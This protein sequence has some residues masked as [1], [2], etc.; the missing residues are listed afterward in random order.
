MAGL[1]ELMSL[2]QFEEEVRR[3]GRFGSNVAIADPLA[4]ALK[5]ISD[6]PAC[7]ESRL[8]GRL[9]HALHEHTGEFRRAEISAFDSR[10]LKIVVALMDTARA[11][12][13]TERQWV[14]AVAAA[15]AANS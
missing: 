5:H 12:T 13:T 10:T 6:N 14:D 15:D 8:L 4:A 3:V 11:G 1:A 9:L 2:T 7:N